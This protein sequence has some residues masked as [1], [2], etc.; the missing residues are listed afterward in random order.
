MLLLLGHTVTTRYPGVASDNLAITWL[1][2]FHWMISRPFSLML[3][4]LYSDDVFQPACASFWSERNPPHVTVTS[5]PSPSYRSRRRTKPWQREWMGQAYENGVVVSQ[6]S[7]V[8]LRR[9]HPCCVWSGPTISV[10]S[11]SSIGIGPIAHSTVTNHTQY[12]LCSPPP[13]ASAL[14]LPFAPIAT[15]TSHAHLLLPAPVCCLLKKATTFCFGELPAAAAA[16]A[17]AAASSDERPTRYY[18]SLCVSSIL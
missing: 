2:K 14:V 6:N 15:P 8:C 5:S 7:T 3:F 4:F 12:Y 18:W 16:A 11:C 10:P 1:H 17:A 9:P 13:I